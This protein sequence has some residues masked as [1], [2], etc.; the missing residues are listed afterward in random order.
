ML[1]SHSDFIINDFQQ[2][3]SSG[4]SLYTYRAALLITLS[5]ILLLAMYTTIV[6][7]GPFRK[8]KKQKN[9]STSKFS[10]AYTV[11]IAKFLIAFFTVTRIESGH[12]IKIL[13]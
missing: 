2:I 3:E 13:T 5:I 6:I 10:S 1:F 8:K 11:T 12:L 7:Y 4:Y 9:N